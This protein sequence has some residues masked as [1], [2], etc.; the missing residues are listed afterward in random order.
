MSRTGAARARGLVAHAAVIALL[1]GSLSPVAALAAS[2]VSFTDIESDLMCTLCHEPLAVAQSS[3]SYSERQFVRTLIAQGLTK[4]QIERQMVAQYGPAV[5]AKPPANGFNLL[6]YVLP[7]VL[8]A[9][10]LG[11]LL[12]TIPRWRRRTRTAVAAAPPASAPSLDPDDADR[13]QQDLARRP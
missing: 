8:L 1:L 9:L 11:T 7:P 13:L 5:L 3:E 10:G 6:V 4:R 2:R 12:V